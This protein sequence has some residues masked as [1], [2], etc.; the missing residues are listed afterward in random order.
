MAKLEAVVPIMSAWYSKVNWTQA[1]AMT[2]TVLTIW[3]VDLDP[4]TQL[5]MVATIQGAAAVAT[6]VFR[7]WFNKSVSPASL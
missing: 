3:G 1:I 4:K 5:A 6:W 2:A 7:T